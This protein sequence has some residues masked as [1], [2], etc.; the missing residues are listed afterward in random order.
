MEFCKFFT[1]WKKSDF[2]S[3]EYGKLMVKLNE[4][5]MKYQVHVKKKAEIIR[6][7]W[8][9]FMI[10]VPWNDNISSETIDHF[11]WRLRMIKIP[12]ISRLVNI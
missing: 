11:D 10:H 3:V 1:L 9:G 5:E 4:I 7:K 6:K 8:N 12:R 2:N